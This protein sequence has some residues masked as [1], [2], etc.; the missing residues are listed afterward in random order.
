[1]DFLKVNFTTLNNKYQ[2]LKKHQ[3]ADHEGTQLFNTSI[4]SVDRGKHSLKILN[5]FILDDSSKPTWEEWVGKMQ[6]KLAVNEDHYL[7]E[8]TCMSYVLSQLSKKATQHT[9]SCSLYEFSVINLYYTTNKILED[10]KK[11]YEDSDKSR[12]YYQAYINLI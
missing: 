7:T 1:M 6:V 12:N 11:I 10:L 5:S 9:E 3:Q 2:L 8:V 4:L